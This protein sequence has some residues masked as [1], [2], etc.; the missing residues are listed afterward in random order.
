MVDTSATPESASTPPTPLATKPQ[1]RR[2]LRWLLVLLGAWLG[3]MMISIALIGLMDWN[4]IK[5]WINEKVSTATGREFSINGDLQVNWTW[6]QPIDTGWRHWV[7]GVVIQANDLRLSQ[8][9]GWSVEQAPDKGSAELPSLPAIPKELNQGRLPEHAASP[10]ST[11][12]KVDKTTA[13]AAEDA[14][15]DQISD[16]AAQPPER[17]SATMAV[18]AR[19]TASLRLWPLLTRH[20]E[21]DSLLLQGPDIVLARRKDGENNWTFKTPES[22]GPPW[23]FGIG[24]LNFSD[25]V[26]GWSDGVKQMAVRARFDSLR[27][28]VSDTQPYGMRFGLTGYMAQGKSRAQIQAQGLIGPVLDLQRDKLRFPLRVSAKAG[29]LQAIA[30]GVLDNP[31]K[32]DG[33]DFQVKLRGKSLADF[34]DLTGLLLPAT[35]PFETSGHLIG[36][37]QPGK[38]TWGY[39]KF[40]G[41]VG[42]SDLSGDLHYSSG[43]ARPKLSGK[44]QSKQLRLADLGPLVGDVSPELS[45]T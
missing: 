15:D 18:A 40:Q 22:A 41:K 28:P 13:N 7:P 45:S 26:L 25:G 16:A 12:K 38:A 8:P 34:F 24:Q 39:E 44:L 43:Q 29:N 27:K 14:D 37:L 33:L 10:K 5:P 31:K 17:S 2:W 20:V 23:T 3:L 19:A 21:L 42:E 9:E 1:R 11:P 36:S 30:E 35:P 4:R 6:P 32:L